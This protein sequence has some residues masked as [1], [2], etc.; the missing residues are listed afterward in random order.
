M[1]IG[2]YASG[3]WISVSSRSRKSVYIRDEGRLI[4]GAGEITKEGI[5]VKIGDSICYCDYW[6]LIVK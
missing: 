4:N 1:D 5:I 3:Q 6:I 2:N